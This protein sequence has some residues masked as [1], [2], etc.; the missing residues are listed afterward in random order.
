M[1]GAPKMKLKI[2]SISYFFC[3]INRF[4]PVA[5]WLRRRTQIFSV[6]LRWVPIILIF[7]ERIWIFIIGQI[8]LKYSNYR[9]FAYPTF[10]ERIPGIVDGIIACL[11]KKDIIERNYGQVNTNEK[12]FAPF[13]RS[14]WATNS[15]LSQAAL[16]EIDSI[17]QKIETL[18]TS[19]QTD[20]PLVELKPIDAFVEEVL[21][22]NKEIRRKTAENNGNPP[23][24]FQTEWLF[25]ECYFYFKLHEIFST[26]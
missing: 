3:P 14:S 6:S 16:N 5:M 21:V 17:I 23:S 2:F 7:D 8:Y 26:R 22:Y 18:K 4:T 15:I 25:A 13:F 24:W 11:R 9:S 12:K 1:R 10:K 20:K 19:M